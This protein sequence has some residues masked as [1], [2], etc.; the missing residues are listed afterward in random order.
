MNAQTSGAPT[1]P[2]LVPLD[3]TPD[4]LAALPVARA[5]AHV[6]DTIMH[7]VHLSDHPVSPEAVRKEL[8]LTEEQ[9]AGAILDV[10]VDRAPDRIARLALE[11]H[12]ILIVM[13]SHDSARP[14][15]GTG[16]GP[17][18]RAVLESCCCPVLFVPPDA[19]AKRW[20]LQRVLLPQD[21]TPESAAAIEPVAHLAQRAG[22]AL[23][24][25]HVSGR[26][27]R[28]PQ[29]R[30]ALP[31]PQYMDQPQHE[32]P[33]W[34]GEFV[35]RVRGLT[36]LPQDT[37]LRLF[38]A[39]G[40]PADEILRIAREQNIDLIALAWHGELK[41]HRAETLKAVLAHASGP[42]L[43]LPLH[44]HRRLSERRKST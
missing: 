44:L 24:V 25:V 31:L 10:V 38:L 8:N 27:V 20:S 13:S 35:E 21:G 29:Q 34:A 30:G 37:E 5:M 12:S 42:V 33:E 41:N 28:E 9:L 43:V 36:N 11:R 23:L 4:S 7:I 40:E 17:V 22:A 1:G 19:P 39:R 3:S 2:I 15:P 18:S 16:L 26:H 6:A 14:E 32:W